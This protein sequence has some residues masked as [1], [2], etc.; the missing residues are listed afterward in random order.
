[1]LSFWS[2]AKDTTFLKKKTKGKRMFWT[3]HWRLSRARLYFSAGLSE[4]D[5]FP[6][7]SEEDVDADIDQQSDDERQVKG[8]HGWVNH[9]VGI[10]NGAHQRVICGTK[11]KWQCLRSK[12]ENML[13]RSMEVLIMWFYYIMQSWNNILCFSACS[14]RDNY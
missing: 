7:H 4:G 12:C 10:R 11:V 14:T 8:H 2:S 3:Y 6:S 1:M 13:K 5:P 9:K